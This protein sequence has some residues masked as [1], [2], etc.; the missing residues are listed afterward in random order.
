MILQG[1][2]EAIA[3]SGVPREELFI[4]DKVWN[5]TIYKGESA[6]R[7][8]VERSLKELQVE[9]IDLYLVH[10]PVPGYHI[11]AFVSRAPYGS[12][13]SIISTGAIIIHMFSSSDLFRGV[14]IIASLFC[15]RLGMIFAEHLRLCTRGAIGD[16]C[17]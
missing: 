2:G 6:I 17:D 11:D 8:Q 5:D 1:V 12:P 4:I 10:W 3:A 7:A 15:V 9:Y 13:F 14:R 16:S